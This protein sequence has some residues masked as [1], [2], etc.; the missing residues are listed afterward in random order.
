LDAIEK[1]DFT[2]PALKELDESKIINIEK[3][4]E[5]FVDPFADVNNESEEIDDFDTSSP[6]VDDEDDDPFS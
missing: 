6:F 4:E 5:K 1:G 2:I 3:K